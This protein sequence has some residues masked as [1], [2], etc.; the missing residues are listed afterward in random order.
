MTLQ[1]RGSRHPAWSQWSG[2]HS[3][4]CCVRPNTRTGVLRA[5]L[6]LYGR[7]RPVREARTKRF[8]NVVYGCHLELAVAAA[9]ERCELSGA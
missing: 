7:G 4:L 9:S 3:I 6:R 8:V 1:F 2:A 5:L